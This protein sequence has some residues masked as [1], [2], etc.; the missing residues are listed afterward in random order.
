MPA[1][2]AAQASTTID[3]GMLIAMAQ[4]DANGNL[5]RNYIQEGSVVFS[6]PKGGAQW[7]TLAVCGAFYNPLK[8]TCGEWW[9]Y[10]YGYCDPEVTPSPFSVAV[11]GTVPLHAKATYAD[12]S[13][14]DFTT[15]SSW[16]SGN[17]SVATVGASTGLVTPASAGSVGIGAQFPSLIVY[18]G[19]LCSTG[20]PIPC[21]TGNLGAGASGTV[22]DATPV[23]ASINPPNWPVGQTTAGSISGQY[24]GTNPSVSLSDTTISFSYQGVSDGQ[25]NFSA[26]VP[27]GDPNGTTSVTVTSNG[28]NGSGF[29]PLPNGGSQARSSPVSADL[30]KL[31]CATATRGSTATC[32]VSN[33]SGISTFT[34]KSVDGQ[35]NTVNYSGA[36]TWSGLVAQSGTVSVT[37]TGLSSPLTASLTVGARTGWPFSA[38]SPTKVSNGSGTGLCSGKLPVLTTPTSSGSSEGQFCLGQAWTYFTQQVGGGPNAGYWYVT[39]ASNVNSSGQATVFQWERVPDLDNTSSTFYE[40]QTGTYNAQTDPTGCISGSNLATQ[41]QRHESGSVQG[42]WGFYNNAQNNSSNNMGTIAEGQVGSPSLT[43]GQFITQVGNALTSAEQTILTATDVEPYPPNYD[44]NGNLL[45]YINYAPSY[46]SC[47]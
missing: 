11:G 22:A 7:M 17:T 19:E 15:S 14:D 31:V 43:S 45:G 26:T 33:T 3:I 13:L 46:N 6:N 37:W 36:S 5:I 44:Q 24:F 4:P 10:C 35:G 18:T 25:I 40:E 34:W 32:T 20:C 28:Y 16:S 30:P 12:G 39:S 2:L 8:A 23:I 21:P 1:H 27:P 38:A 42:H 47:K 9:T 29:I 41:T